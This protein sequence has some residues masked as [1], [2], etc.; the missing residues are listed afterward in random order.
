MSLIRAYCC[1]CKLACTDDYHEECKTAV[2]DYQNSIKETSVG[3]WENVCADMGRSSCLTY[4]GTTKCPV[5]NRICPK[6]VRVT[7]RKYIVI[8]DHNNE[9]FMI[10]FYE[11]NV[12]YPDHEPFFSVYTD[13]DDIL[14][15]WV[16]RAKHETIEEH[17]L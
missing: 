5:H 15:K 7:F 8:I 17:V 13:N 12:P 3:E 2:D 6:K 16:L 1:Y 4:S 10:D 14:F 9:Y 11:D